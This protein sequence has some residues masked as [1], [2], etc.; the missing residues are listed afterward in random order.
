MSCPALQPGLSWGAKDYVLDE[1]LQVFMGEDD[2]LSVANHVGTAPA[3]ATSVVDTG[4]RMLPLVRV[5][6]ATTARLPLL[7]VDVVL[8]VCSVTD[9]DVEDAPVRLF[10]DSPCAWPSAM[11]VVVAACVALFLLGQR[12]NARPCASLRARASWIC[13]LR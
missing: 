8:C 7:E 2:R 1:P 10:F 13:I 11:S 12:R 6:R 4:R 3:S 5:W 9:V